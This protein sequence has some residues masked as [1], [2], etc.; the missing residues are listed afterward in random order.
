MPKRKTSFNSEWIKE[1]EFITKSSR[2]SYHGFC[3]LCRCDVDVSSQGKAAIERHAGTDK[4][5]SNKRAAGTS[6][7]R[8]FFRE[9]SSPLD[10]KI[11]AAGLCKV[12]HAVKHHQSY[13]S[14]DCGMKVDREIFSDSPT[15][16][17]MACGRT[18]AKA[19]CKNV[20]APYSVQE[21][22]LL[23]LSCYRG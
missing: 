21:Q 8:T 7:M 1:H 17:G 19:L 4:H 22:Q 16:K 11:T 20:I 14:L 9:V 23:I 6:S 18:K 15:A 13:R 5:K 2:D 12:Y 10:D 3:T